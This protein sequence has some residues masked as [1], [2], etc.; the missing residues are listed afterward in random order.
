ML[1]AFID[2]FSLYCKNLSYAENSIKE[3]IRYTNDFNNFINKQQLKIPSEIHYIHL[4]EFLALT[5]A[6]PNTVK[7]RLWTLKKFFNFLKLNDY[8]KNNITKSL[9]PPK[10]P[11]KETAFFTQMELKIIFEHLAANLTQKNGLRDFLLFSFMAVLGLRKSSV[12]KINTEDID[13]INQRIF[14]QEKGLKSKRPILIPLSI[15]TL[16]KEFISRNNLSKGPLF[17]LSRNNKRLT[18][19][20]LDKIVRLIKESLLAL[21]HTF[22]KNLHPHILRHS[23]ATQVNE[24]AGFNITR[25]MLGHKNMQNT[26][27]YIHLSPTAYA[28]YM[29]RHPYFSTERNMI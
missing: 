19:N 3:L 7:G 1:N 12:I 23:A 24:I 25:D 17:L 6:T 9:S 28:N 11:I 22:A 2:E 29:K 10:I 14:I 8:I 27:K 18:L 15:F 21:N 16:L 4:H 13:V 26:R 5:P 20:T